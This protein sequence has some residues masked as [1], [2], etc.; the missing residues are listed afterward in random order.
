MIHDFKNGMF[1]KIEYFLAPPHV[2]VI[3][4]KALT[5]SKDISTDLF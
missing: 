4:S 3:F 1:Y 2:H 5:E